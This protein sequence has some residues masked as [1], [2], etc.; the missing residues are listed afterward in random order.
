MASLPFN[1]K[2]IPVKRTEVVLDLLNHEPQRTETAETAS[3]SGASAS[4][5]PRAAIPDLLTDSVNNITANVG[6]A[7]ES[8]DLIDLSDPSAPP[9]LPF[10]EV[11]PVEIGYVYPRALLMS[12]RSQPVRF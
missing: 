3:V 10:A 2:P 6:Q 4:A 5:S 7:D 8:V 1:M 11:S 12:L 9:L